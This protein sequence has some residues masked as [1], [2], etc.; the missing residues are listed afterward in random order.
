MGTWLLTFV[1]RLCKFSLVTCSSLVDL[2]AARGVFLG[3]G[4]PNSA[5][6]VS[7]VFLDRVVVGEGLA[8][9]W[10]NHRH[11]SLPRQ[12]IVAHNTLQYIQYREKVICYQLEFGK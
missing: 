3:R 11:F 6:T 10:L 4:A 12:E 1:S 8:A 9:A 5:A 2:S 7:L